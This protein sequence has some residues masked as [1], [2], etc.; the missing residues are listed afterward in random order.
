MLVLG[1]CV[2]PTRVIVLDSTVPLGIYGTVDNVPWSVAW[3]GSITSRAGHAITNQ[4]ET[5]FRAG[6]LSYQS[7]DIGFNNFEPVRAVAVVDPNVQELLS[8]T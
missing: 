1:I 8:T 4:M 2:G 7:G 5:P 3:V 6:K